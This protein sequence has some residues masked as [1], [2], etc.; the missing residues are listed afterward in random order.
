MEYDEQLTLEI[1]VA[2]GEPRPWGVSVWRYMSEYRE[3]FVARED[4][5]AYALARN[6]GDDDC[7][8]EG[9]YR[10]DGRLDEDAQRLLRPYDYR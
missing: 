2:Q 10:P 7:F 9:V 5:L 3:P 1:P 6:E 4:A 8:I